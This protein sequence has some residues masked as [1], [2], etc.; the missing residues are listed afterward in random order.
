HDTATAR[1]IAGN[2]D[3][4]GLDEHA[5]VLR[6]DVDAYVR[7][8]VPAAPFDVVLVDPPYD[9]ATSEI[10]AVLAALDGPGWLASGAVVVVERRRGSGAVTPPGG[11]ARGTDRISG[12]T[13]VVVLPPPAVPA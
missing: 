5:L 6:T 4:T 2:L 3:V 13:L 7:R 10:D 1:V 9:V 11:W 12:D 8:P